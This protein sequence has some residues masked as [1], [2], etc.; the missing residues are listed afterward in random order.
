MAFGNADHRHSTHR[1]RCTLRM[2]ILCA[3]ALLYELHVS[4]MV[5]D[6]RAWSAGETSAHR[7]AVK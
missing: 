2:R 3:L 5:R 6:V 4:C 1:E 7:G